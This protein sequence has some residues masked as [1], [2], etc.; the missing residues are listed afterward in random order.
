MNSNN[1][2]SYSTCCDIMI[3]FGLWIT[4][5]AFNI[6][7][8][9][10][11]HNIWKSYCVK[12]NLWPYAFVSFLIVILSL[13][14]SSSI[15]KHFQENY[16]N[17]LKYVIVIQTFIYLFMTFWGIIELFDT[18]WIEPISEYNLCKKLYK[19]ELWDIAVVNFSI[20]GFL[21]IILIIEFIKNED[22]YT[23]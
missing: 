18:T 11:Y 15:Y 5:L 12:T 7:F 3:F 8:L 20:I 9:N 19:S 13:L 10:R 14:F 17:L 22:F 4:Y 2:S 6:D 1:N 21:T 23:N 16:R